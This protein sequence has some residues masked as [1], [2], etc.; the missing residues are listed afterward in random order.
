MSGENDFLLNWQGNIMDVFIYECIYPN[1]LY[2]LATFNTYSKLNK[3][4]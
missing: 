1:Y 2:T 4:T 3:L